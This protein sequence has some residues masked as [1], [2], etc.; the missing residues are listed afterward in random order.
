MKLPC[1]N[2]TS[3]SKCAVPGFNVIH[4]MP[5][6]QLD[7]NGCEFFRT[8]R[9]THR[10]DQLQ[11]PNERKLIMDRIRCM[12]QTATGENDLAISRSNPAPS[13][14]YEPQR[15]GS[16]VFNSVSG[17]QTRGN[18]H[19]HQEMGPRRPPDPV[20]SDLLCYKPKCSPTTDA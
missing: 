17:V 6:F 13:P 2:C 9:N 19:H 11:R 5:C 20:Y 7:M 3:P 8:S 15:Q 14:I 18:R 10:H 16:M 12:V 1:N 4:S